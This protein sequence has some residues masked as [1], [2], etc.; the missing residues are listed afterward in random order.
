MCH[1]RHPDDRPDYQFHRRSSAGRTGFPGW[2][3]QGSDRRNSRIPIGRCWSRTFS[4][5]RTTRDRHYGRSGGCGG[6]RMLV[7]PERWGRF[8]AGH[9]LRLQASYPSPT[10]AIRVLRRARAESDRLYAVWA[11]HPFVRN[12]SRWTA[13]SVEQSPCSRRI[14]DATRAERQFS[15]P[16]L[17]LLSRR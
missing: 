1:R 4:G 11:R 10:I 14:C 6:R 13:T 16:V 5:R 12:Y 15:R 7:L 3:L 8:R 9:M 2:L 17:Q